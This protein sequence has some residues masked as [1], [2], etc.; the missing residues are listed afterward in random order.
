MTDSIVPQT[1][2]QWRHCITE[3]CQ[4]PL[5]AEYIEKRL[6]S[7]NNPNDHTTAQFVQLYG[8]KQRI[9]TLQWFEQAKAELPTQ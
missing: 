3:I 8:E 5:T 7:L 6:Q 9:H 1:Y 4:I 2:E